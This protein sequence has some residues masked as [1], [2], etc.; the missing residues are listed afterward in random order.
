M[1]GSIVTRDSAPIEI[2]P[3]RLSIPGEE[4]QQT[5]HTRGCWQ[6]PTTDVVNL[7]GV[8]NLDIQRD[9]RSCFQAFVDWFWGWCSDRCRGGR[10]RP[11]EDEL[12]LPSAPRLE[13]QFSYYPGRLIKENDMMPK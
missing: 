5:I 7:R 3:R 13:R 1:C 8:Q 6:L 10:I 9:T 12:P 4:V 11:I 2:P